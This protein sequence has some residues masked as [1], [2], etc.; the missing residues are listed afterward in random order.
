[1]GVLD[2]GD[3]EDEDEEESKRE[4]WKQEG[5]EDEN[6]KEEDHESVSERVSNAS[7]KKNLRDL[8]RKLWLAVEVGDKLATLKIL[9]AS[10]GPQN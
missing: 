9:Q 4:D 1:M 8:A 10:P 3:E 7:S 6:I 2:D 5:N